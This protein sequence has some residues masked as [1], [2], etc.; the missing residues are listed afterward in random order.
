[1]HYFQMLVGAEGVGKSMLINQFLST[2]ED[3]ESL[4]KLGAIMNSTRKLNVDNEEYSLELIECEEFRYCSNPH[5][6]PYCT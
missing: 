5:F 2:S 3:R 1:M 6:P 4:N